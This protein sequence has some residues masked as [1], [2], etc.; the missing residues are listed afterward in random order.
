MLLTLLSP[1]GAEGSVVGA[2]A[3]VAPIITLSATADGT[4]A[5]SSITAVTGTGSAIA[6]AITLS[7]IASGTGATIAPVSGTGSAIAPALTLSATAAGVGA[8]A[9][10]TAVTG[11]GA[12]QAP[13]LTLSATASG[14]GSTTDLNFT[15]QGSQLDVSVVSLSSGNTQSSQAD[16]LAIYNIPAIAAEV[17][18]G[19]VTCVS[20]SMSN[21]QVSQFDVIAITNGRIDDPAIRAWTYTLDGHD[22]YVLRLGNSE[23]LI[24]DF[25]T[26]QWAVW[27]TGEEDYWSVY[28]GTNWV[29]GNTYSATFGSNIIVGSDANGSLFFLDPNK[30]NDDA[31]LSEREPVS[32][33]R[34]VTGQIPVRGYDYARV[35]EVQLLGSVSQLNVGATTGFEL[36]Y[37]DDRGDTYTSAGTVETVDGDYSIRGS[38]RSL[39]SFTSP[40]RLFRVKDTG[41][42][43]RIDSLTVSTNL[44]A[45]G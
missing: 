14:A 42:L 31:V 25:A 20:L 15:V 37:S 38:W 23:T 33:T 12:A 27:A 30:P 16:V 34:A 26:E 8:Q 35:F 22:F 29:G 18:A 21:V 7:V 43:K 5:Q 32:F 11:T 40:G 9:S 10:I 36:L 41:A 2:G 17:S 3:A 6:P 19:D 39:G 1:Q 28:T 4:G 13:A 45:E 44:K 24:Y